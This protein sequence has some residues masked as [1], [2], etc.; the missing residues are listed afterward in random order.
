LFYR[1]IAELEEELKIVGN[2]MR[3]LEIAEQ[4]V[5]YPRFVIFCCIPGSDAC[6][7]CVKSPEHSTT[8]VKMTS[9]VGQNLRANF[10]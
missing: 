9:A 8:I 7:F 3:S 1:K 2:N 5:M 6:E 4:E 10:V